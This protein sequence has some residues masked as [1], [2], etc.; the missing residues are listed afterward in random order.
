MS[1]PGGANYLFDEHT[2]TLSY[3]LSIKKDQQVRLEWGLDM[4]VNHFNKQDFLAQHFYENTTGRLFLYAG[5]YIYRNAHSLRITLRPGIVVPVKNELSVP[6]TQ[7]NIYTEHVVDPEYHFRGA[8]F[9]NGQLGVLFYTPS[10]LRMAGS[11]L[12]LGLDYLKMLREDE[13]E[14][15]PDHSQHSRKNQTHLSIGFQIFL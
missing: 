13:P 2:A 12:S 8:S 11:A 14:N 3:L 15:Q 1:S 6:E 10:L 7:R 4:D 5:R 9:F